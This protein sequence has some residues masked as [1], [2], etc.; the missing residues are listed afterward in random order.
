MIGFGAPLDFWLSWKM[1]EGRNYGNFRKN[2]YGRRQFLGREGGVLELG[3]GI[4]VIG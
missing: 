2:F 3:F 1:A 4:P